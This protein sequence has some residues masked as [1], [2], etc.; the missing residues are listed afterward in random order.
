VPLLC[1]AALWWRAATPGRPVAAPR[2][3]RA[4]RRGR[5]HLPGTG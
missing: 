4:L 3:E 1:V 5:G 2:L